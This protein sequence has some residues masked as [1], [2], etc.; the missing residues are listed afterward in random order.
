MNFWFAK[1]SARNLKFQQC[2]QSIGFRLAILF[3]GRE[4]RCAGEEK[5][6]GFQHA[7][8]RVAADLLTTATAADP[9]GGGFEARRCRGL[10]GLAGQALSQKWPES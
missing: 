10:E 3:G 2:W 7:A 1:K 6:L 8:P 5:E 4:R 9:M